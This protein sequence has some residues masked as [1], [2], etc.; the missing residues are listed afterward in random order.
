MAGRF[1]N[2][3]MLPCLASPD[4]SQCMPMVRHVAIETASISLSSKTLTHIPFCQWFNSGLFF[5]NF[6]FFGNSQFI[7]IAK[8]F[9]T[10]HYG[11]L[12]VYTS[13]LRVKL[14]RPP[15]PITA[16]LIRSLA[17]IIEAYDLELK[18]IPP[19]ANSGSSQ[20][21]FLNK[22]SSFCHFYVIS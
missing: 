3:N 14:P 18:P 11:H 22:I 5:N 1:F 21:A 2:I 8:W 20:Y 4:C 15:I 6:S 12:S 7:S 10:V 19:M 16:I 17:P 13:F 9:L